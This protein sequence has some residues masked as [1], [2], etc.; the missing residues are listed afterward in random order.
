MNTNKGG[1]P[2]SPEPKKG[3]SFQSSSQGTNSPHQ[4]RTWKYLHKRKETRKVIVNEP[5]FAYKT[6][7]EVFL[8]FVAFRKINKLVETHIEHNKSFSTGKAQAVT[9]S[10]TQKTV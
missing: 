4:T 10:Q 1:L 2:G 3:T 5:M 9:H 8:Y 7:C 6:N